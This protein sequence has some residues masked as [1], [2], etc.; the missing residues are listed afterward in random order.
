MDAHARLDDEAVTD[1]GGSV[2]G[3]LE[4]FDA[5]GTRGVDAET[6]RL[7]VA[8]TAQVDGEG[9]FVDV[10]RAGDVICRDRDGRETLETGAQFLDAERVAGVGAEE[11]AEGEVI[12]GLRVDY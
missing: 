11:A 6:A 10:G 8:V 1:D 7:P 12:T 5:Q 3:V 4:A 2:G 9:T